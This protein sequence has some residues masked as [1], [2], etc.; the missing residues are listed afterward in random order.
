M[1]YRGDITFRFGD[2]GEVREF[3][4]VVFEYQQDHIVGSGNSR[5]FQFGKLSVQASNFDD[6]TFVTEI[7][8]LAEG[9]EPVYLEVV[10]GSYAASFFQGVVTFPIRQ[11]RK[12][13]SPG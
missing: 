6:C 9:A 7:D 4:D 3:Q 10:S 5:V 11:R 2:S 12:D 13:D 1:H 8:L